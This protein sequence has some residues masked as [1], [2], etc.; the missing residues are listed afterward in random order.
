MARNDYDGVVEAVH[1]SSD[2][3]VAWV[4]AYEKRGPTFSERMM[5]DRETLVARLKDG[6]RYVSGK[7]IPYLA[8]TF[9]VSDALHLVNKDGE[10]VLVTGDRQAETDNLEGVPII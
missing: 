2:G 4:R 1:Y 8:S 10:E 7:R 9:D 3:Q 6:K 5:L